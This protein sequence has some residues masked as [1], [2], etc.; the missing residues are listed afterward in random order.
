MMP[1]ASPPTRPISL[2]TPVPPLHGGT[3]PA[4]PHL[5]S[6]IGMSALASGRERHDR[7]LGRHLS[8]L[9][10]RQ[11]A[12]HVRRNVT[13]RPS[14]AGQCRPKTVHEREP[15]CDF[16]IGMGRLAFSMSCSNARNGLAYKSSSHG[17]RRFRRARAGS[18][19]S[20]RRKQ[21]RRV[22]SWRDT[23]LLPAAPGAE[24]ARGRRVSFETHADAR[25]RARD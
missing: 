24:R 11:S 22:R 8:R 20:G 9:A 25:R 10:S 21:Q 15:R 1:A 17:D 5:T 19:V 18:R 14:P 13:G 2:Q 4:V 6:V 23:R 7:S 16:G 3:Y 12:G